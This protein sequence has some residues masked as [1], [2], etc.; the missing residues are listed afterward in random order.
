MKFNK[1]LIGL[2]AIAPFALASCNNA[3][4]YEDLQSWIAGHYTHGSTEADKS[5]AIATFIWDYHATTSNGP[6]MTIV[7]EVF[8]TLSTKAKKLG[9]SDGVIYFP[10]DKDKPS[11]GEEKNVGIINYIYPLNITELG[12]LNKDKD[13]VGHFGKKSLNKDKVWDGTYKETFKI[14]DNALTVSST[15]EF[16]TSALGADPIDVSC[17]YAY[18]QEG[19]LAGYAFKIGRHY[20]DSDN[21]VKLKVSVELEYSH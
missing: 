2:M 13:N 1:L 4:S 20:I 18:N 19:Y 5:P 17:T 14:Y 15:E 7:K 16:S 3:V 6:G 12:K 10:G 9:I 11:I 8:T 21:I